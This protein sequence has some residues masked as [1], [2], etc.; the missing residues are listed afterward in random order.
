MDT[1]LSTSRRSLPHQ[2]AV[3]PASALTGWDESRRGA[4]LRGPGKAVYLSDGA[5]L[6]R[7]SIPVSRHVE[8][9][10]LGS[11]SRMAMIFVCTLSLGACATHNL[12]MP[13]YVGSLQNL[14]TLRATGAQGFSVGN[15]ADAPSAN[16]PGSVRARIWILQPPNNESFSGYLKEALISELESAGRY[17]A[18]SSLS[19]GGV[20][21][22]NRLDA[23]GVN[24]G[25]A[26]LSVRFN[27]TNAGSTVYEKTLT[28]ESRWDSSFFGAIAV[29]AAI[30]NYVGTFHKL[31]Y[32]LFA[33]PEFQKLMAT[34]P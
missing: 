2:G 34:N 22:D 17:R 4:G 10:L 20:L 6:R 19:I 25:T 30:R 5:V 15:F 9:E 23:S 12:L 1:E 33:D 11:I 32:Q 28:A 18:D 8:M 21:L 13:M 14:Q 29:P 27:V 3:V 24:F 26:V 31:L 16:P 7:A